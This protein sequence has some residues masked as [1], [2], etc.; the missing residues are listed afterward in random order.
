VVQLAHRGPLDPQV[1][2]DLQDNKVFKAMLVPL[3]HPVLQAHKEILVHRALLVRRALMV[4]G[5]LLV[6][7]A[8][9]VSL[10]LLAHKVFKVM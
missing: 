4:H 8:L 9:K 6:L 5:D 3:E 10:A 2:K 7:P 1:L